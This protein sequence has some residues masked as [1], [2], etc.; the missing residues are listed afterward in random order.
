[1]NWILNGLPADTYSVENAI[2]IHNSLRNS[3]IIDP[4]DQSIRWIKM[5]EKKS[6]IIQTRINAPDLQRQVVT[7]I[8]FGYVLVVDKVVNEL[9]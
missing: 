9:N 6:K 5:N 1:M 2:I 3:L 7:C 4:Q 8:Q